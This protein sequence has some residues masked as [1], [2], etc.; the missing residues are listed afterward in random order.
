[1]E[2][3]WKSFGEPTPDSELQAVIGY[4]NPS[5]YLTVPKVLW[6]TRKIEAQLADSDGLVGYALRANVAQK[7]FWAVAAWE[8]DESLQN[9]VETEPH[10]GIRLALKAEMKES[11]FKRFDVVGGDLPLSIDEG[12]ERV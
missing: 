6:N 9:Y 12:L 8:R 4:L 10:A 3:A 11:W 5:G 7:K 2:S 1:M